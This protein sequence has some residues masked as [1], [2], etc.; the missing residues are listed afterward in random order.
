MIFITADTHGEYERF[1]DKQLKPLK[2]GDTLIV[3]GDFGFIWNNDKPETKMLKKIS[4]LHFKVLFIDG[5]NENLTAID[6]YPE[7]MYHGAAARE[8]YKNKIYYIKRGEIL[9]LESKKIMCFGGADSFIPEFKFEQYIPG[10]TDFETCVA[11]LSQHGN[12]VDYILTHLPSGK[13][14]RFINLESSHTSGL[15]E[16]FDAVTDNVEYTKWYFGSV[17]QD[18]HISSKAQAVY[19][20]VI[21][22]KD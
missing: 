17:H 9:E 19:R 22:I 18:K 1:C 7:V 4:K 8:I 5:K 14:N 13:I 15:M 16:F 21:Q 2:I 20:N 10:Q 12:K 11:N 6:T 3:L